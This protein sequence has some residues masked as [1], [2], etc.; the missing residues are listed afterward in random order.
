MW[1]EDG[2][3]IHYIERRIVLDALIDEVKGFHM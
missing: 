1:Y 2:T 3:G